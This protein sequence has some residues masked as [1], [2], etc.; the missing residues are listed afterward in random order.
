MDRTSEPRPRGRPFWR[1]G[2]NGP[3]WLWLM[4]AAVPVIITVAIVGVLLVNTGADDPIDP[5][6]NVPEALPRI[7]E[8]P[9]EFYGEQVTVTGEVRQTP[10]LRVFTLVGTD[11][12]ADQPLLVIGMDA[13]PL[14]YGRPA[15]TPV[16][17]RDTV[18]ATGT[19]REFRIAEI[20]E[21]LGIDLD[22][23]P[24]ALTEFEGRPVVLAE[25]LIIWAPGAARP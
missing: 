21:E 22:L 5:G 6:P 11:G 24:V 7:L 10:A 19:L 17:E 13:D 14:V 2:A 18:R 15:G 9:E 20:E 8:E 16:D 25:D 23:D 4:L 3:G 12:I 1:P